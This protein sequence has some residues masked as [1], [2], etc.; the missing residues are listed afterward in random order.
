VGNAH[1]NYFQG[2]H[3]PTLPTQCRRP[4]MYDTLLPGTQ[5]IDI[6]E[7]LDRVVQ[8]GYLTSPKYPSV[9]PTNVDC[10]CTLM[11]D[12]EDAR[13]VISFYD[14]LLETKLGRCRAD[15]IMLRQNGQTSIKLL[16]FYY[17][18]GKRLYT[19]NTCAISTLES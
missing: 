17:N 1:P 5:A 19:I 10:K 3:L 4:C 18:S 13:I 6:C 7:S 8:D 9:Y 16:L 2:G 12:R 15:W 11:A 14:L